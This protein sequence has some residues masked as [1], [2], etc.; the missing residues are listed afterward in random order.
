MELKSHGVD[1]RTSLDNAQ[2]AMLFMLNGDKGKEYWVGFKNFYVITRYNRSLMYAMA[3]RDLS[4][5]VA[6]RMDEQ[7]VAN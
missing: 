4:D 7:L 3:V 6:A 5:I 2:S 1:V